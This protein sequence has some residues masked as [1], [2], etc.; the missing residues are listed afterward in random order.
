MFVY[1][2]K[3]QTTKKYYTG[4][5]TN[6]ARR[7]KEHNK[8]RTGSVLHTKNLGPFKLVHLEEVFDREHARLREKFWKSGMGREI[9]D[10]YLL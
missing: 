1:I 5:T 9:R 6:I 10:N 2:I 3:C 7:M 8:I 4:L